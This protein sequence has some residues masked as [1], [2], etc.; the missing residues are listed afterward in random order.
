[1]TNPIMVCADD[2]AL[3]EPISWGILELAQ[4][5]RISAISCMTESCYWP[6]HARA[7]DFAG[8]HVALGLHF[9]LTEGLHSEDITL[10]QCIHRSISG[11]IDRRAISQR[12]HQQL[13]RSYSDAKEELQ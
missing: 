7:L 6:E 12:L 2:Y 3:S 10:H 4:K 9:N 5:R 8:K 11:H 1:M 13:D